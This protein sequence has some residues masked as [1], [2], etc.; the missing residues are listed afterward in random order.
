MG[1]QNT[2]PKYYLNFPHKVYD[3]F[4]QLKK[5]LTYVRGFELEKTQFLGHPPILVEAKRLVD[6]SMQGHAATDGDLFCDGILGALFHTEMFSRLNHFLLSGEYNNLLVQPEIV[7]KVDA[8]H[9]YT[10]AYASWINEYANAL[11]TD[12]ETLKKFKKILQDRAT[13]PNTASINFRPDLYKTFFDKDERMKLVAGFLD[14]NLPELL[15]S[16]EAH[17]HFTQAES[18]V[19]AST[20]RRYLRRFYEREYPLHH[21][22]ALYSLNFKITLEDHFLSCDHKSLARLVHYR[23]QLR[24]YLG[25]YIGPTKD[26]KLVPLNHAEVELERETLPV[27]YVMY[28]RFAAMNEDVF[29][30]FEPGSPHVKPFYEEFDR[31]LCEKFTPVLQGLYEKVNF[32]IRKLLLRHGYRPVKDHEMKL[33]DDQRIPLIFLNRG[34]V[35]FSYENYQLGHYLFLWEKFAKYDNTETQ[36]YLETKEHDIGLYRNLLDAKHNDDCSCKPLTSVGAYDFATRYF[37]DFE[38]DPDY[39]YKLYES[40]KYHIYNNALLIRRFNTLSPKKQQQLGIHYRI[41]RKTITELDLEPQNETDWAAIKQMCNYLFY[42]FLSLEFSGRVITPPDL[43]KARKYMTEV[44]LLQEETKLF[45][46]FPYYKY[47]QYLLKSI[48]LRLEVNKE[49]NLSDIYFRLRES[50]ITT[51]HYFELCKRND[52]I[53]FNLPRKE[54]FPYADME[55]ADKQKKNEDRF[56]NKRVPQETFYELKSNQWIKTTDDLKLYIAT[57]FVL[58]VNYEET[59]R[60]INELKA[61]VEGVGLHQ[62][63]MI[64]EKIRGESKTLKEDLFKTFGWFTGIV[65]FVVGGI[66]KLSANHN[67]SLYGDLMFMASLGMCLMIFL[68]A[69]FGITK[70]RPDNSSR[71]YLYVKA[72]LEKSVD[73]TVYSVRPRYRRGFWKAIKY[74]LGRG[75]L[76]LDRFTYYLT[77]GGALW[78]AGF[79]IIVFSVLIYLYKDMA[80]TENL[81]YEKY[82]TDLYLNARTQLEKDVEDKIQSLVIKTKSHESR[83][84][85]QAK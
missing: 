27:D 61:K 84:L 54:C 48:N 75:L 40:F 43:E 68:F 7:N 46:F 66:F 32:L 6:A 23:D 12:Y 8:D 33:L 80:Q 45:S 2:P 44:R 77:G 50:L 24:N 34:V 13:L 56:I 25:T 62:V 15:G 49:T 42:S 5:L 57:A 41:D 73:G 19:S 21:L 70:T 71:L 9:L 81:V 14:D 1:K 79:F 82:Q 10:N 47:S 4:E 37:R 58:P 30:L 18:K 63:I 28:P 36:V 17:Y 22:A 74:W 60:R 64:D 26:K 11:S 53:P 51:D 38:P 31:I 83:I 39:A 78:R 3:S 59:G 76:S 55:E 16:V 52:Y 35:H 69:L 67:G 85:R 65:S 29:G 20:K 72:W